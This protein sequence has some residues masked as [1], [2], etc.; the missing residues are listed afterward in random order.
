MSFTHLPN[1]LL[2]AAAVFAA[3]SLAAGA[4]T[5]G[6]PERYSATIVNEPGRGTTPIQIAVDRWSTDKERDQLVSTLLDK[7]PEKLLDVLKDMPTVGFIRTPTSLAWDL[8]FARKTALPDGGEQ[9]VLA[10][11]RPISFWEQAEQPRTLDYP[12]TVIE[13]RLKPNGEGEGKLS[14]ATKV[15]A[16]KETNTVVLEN[17][18]TQPALI[19]AVK[20]ED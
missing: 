7:G 18:G 14:L 19:Q 16:D 5:S 11:D 3:A 10:T 17:Y 12:F 15:I 9:V 1:R 6:S 20:R 4:Q 13:L 8:R 2:G